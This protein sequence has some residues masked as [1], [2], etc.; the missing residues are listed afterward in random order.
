MLALL[1]NAPRPSSEREVVGPVHAAMAGGAID[2][3]S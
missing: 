1:D 2:D 3:Y